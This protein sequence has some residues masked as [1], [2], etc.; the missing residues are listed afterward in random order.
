VFSIDKIVAAPV[1]HGVAIQIK[2]VSWAKRQLWAQD[3]AFKNGKYYLYFPAKDQQD[4]FRI[5][6]AISNSPTGPFRPKVNPIAASF[7]ID[8]AVF[9]DTDGEIYMYWGGIWCGQLQK[10][11][12]RKI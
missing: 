10:K 1:D 2:D 4:I 5:G 11:A 7:S 9:T 6:V 12:D 8:P 3:A